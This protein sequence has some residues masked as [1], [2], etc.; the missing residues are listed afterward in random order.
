MT[1][2]SSLGPRHHRL[3]GLVLRPRRWAEGM[4]HAPCLE[5]PIRATAS[6]ALAAHPRRP[7]RPGVQCANETGSAQADGQPA[8]SDLVAN[9]AHHR[10]HL[11]GEGVWEY[12]GLSMHPFSMSTYRG[13]C[14]PPLPRPLPPRP[15][16]RLRPSVVLESRRMESSTAEPPSVSFG[17]WPSKCHTDQRRSLR[18]HR[19]H[20]HR[21]RLG[22]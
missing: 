21:L 7:Q 9:R 22:G 1:P 10:L 13:G 14:L 6:A 20:R 5:L 11:G 8:G 12:A 19:P 16:S 3:C 17:Q 4:P 15:L 18:T 2:L